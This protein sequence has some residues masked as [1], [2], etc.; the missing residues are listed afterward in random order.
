M[1]D[2]GRATRFRPSQDGPD[3]LGS[4]GRISSA[5]RSGSANTAGIGY[6][7]E[8]KNAT[9]VINLRARSYDPSV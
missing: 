6:A 2:P 7:G 4:A 9:G 1:A 8:W 5:P 3:A